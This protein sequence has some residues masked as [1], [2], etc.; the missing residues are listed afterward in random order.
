MIDLKDFQTTVNHKYWKH[1][2]KNTIY[3]DRNSYN[4]DKLYKE[5]VDKVNKGEYTPYCIREHFIYNK[6]REI[7]NRV[8]RVVPL[9]DIRDYLLIYYLL[10]K[11]ESNLSETIHPNAFGSFRNFKTFRDIENNNFELLGFD[12][13]PS[14][15]STSSYN[16]SYWIFEWREFMGMAHRL[17]QNKKY[18]FFIQFDIADFYPSINL[19]ILERKLRA[20]VTKENQQYLDL[21]LFFLHNY[22]RRF[23][24]YIPEMKG[25]P[26]DELGDASRMLANFYLQSFDHKINNYAN[27]LDAEVL[28]FA[29]DHIIFAKNERDATNILF[30]ASI[31]LQKLGLFVNGAKVKDFQNRTKFKNYWSFDIHK[32]LDRHRLKRA[33][34]LYSARDKN[35]FRSYSILLRFLNISPRFFSSSQYL[36]IC[37]D[38]LEPALLNTLDYKKMI[39]LYDFLPQSEKGKYLIELDTLSSI[40]MFNS[41]HYNLL[42]SIEVNSDFRKYFDSKRLEKIYK[43]IDVLR[44]Y[45]ND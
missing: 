41:F 4:K 40:N 2:I 42:K 30:Y 34:I 35:S 8:A 37:K 33:I 24:N 45:F 17:Y 44:G 18:K 5:I 22:N 9:F 15:A 7:S 16:K 36:V 20:S 26:Q 27:T 31:N 39:K 43:R 29:D 25:L 11:I 21:L 28:R 13:L 32:L 14:V 1:L 23:S 6:S 3:P 19:N 10:R 38:L 12:S